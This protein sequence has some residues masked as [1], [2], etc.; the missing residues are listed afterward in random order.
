MKWLAFMIVLVG[1]NK[2]VHVLPPTFHTHK[3]W[4]SESYLTWQDADGFGCGH[5]DRSNNGWVYEAQLIDWGEKVEYE[6]HAEFNNFDDAVKFVEQW[7]K[8]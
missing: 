8:P 6:P 4:L 7:C 1:C 2:P 3:V 5:I